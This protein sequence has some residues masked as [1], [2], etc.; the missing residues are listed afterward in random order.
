M[1][2]RK[3]TTNNYRILNAVISDVTLS[4]IITKQGILFLSQRNVVIPKGMMSWRIHLTNQ[5]IQYL[6]ILPGKKPALVVWTRSDRAHFYDLNTGTLLDEYRLPDL[7]ENTNRRS[8][9]WQAY[10]GNLYGPDM[11]VYLPHIQIGA[12]DVY[13]TDDGKLRL[14]HTTDGKYHMETDGAETTLAHVPNDG[15]I[16]VDLDRALGT[17]VALDYSRQLHIY[18]QN[19]YMGVFDIGLNDD[20]DSRPHIM[21]TRGGSSIFASDG[22]KIVQANINGEVIKTQ[23]VH[24]RI[25]HMACSPGGGMILTHDIE[26]GVLRVYQG[27]TL[28][29][30]HQKHAIDLVLAANQIQ[31]LADLPPLDTGISAIALHNR[32]TICFAMSGVV[33]V[34][35]V[36]VM[37]ELPRPQR[38]L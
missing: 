24:Y 9:E 38:L 11:S 1:C 16:A 15:F 26:T 8:E 6:H 4:R 25:S 20:R 32:G 13:C 34:S 17:F 12:T 28:I 36:S 29:R 18:Q 10:V 27:D 7:P 33:C 2:N 5:A 19:I 37:D 21:V 35:D 30:T 23:E 3:W 31:L 22:H 14:Y